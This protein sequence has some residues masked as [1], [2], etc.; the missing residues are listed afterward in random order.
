VT[1]AFE[2]NGSLDWTAIGTLAL[3]GVTFV[4]L[5]FGRR[6]L[7]QTKEE[8]DVSRKE[9]EEAHRPV[10]VPTNVV[11]GQNGPG[12]MV[13]V[14]LENIGTGPALGLRA[15][16]VLLTSDGE[17]AGHGGEHANPG[18]I[19]LGAGAEKVLN[20]ETERWSKGAC[21]ALDAIYEDVA[22]K[23]WQT[24]GN[25]LDDAARPGVWERVRSSPAFSRKRSS[26]P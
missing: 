7:T 1:V 12:S 11:W 2:F 19:A 25:Y 26:Q 8:I 9:V 15:S 14:W 4:S 13:S 22:G 16:I 3:A 5:V 21:F 24:Q 10:V 18:E 20:V 23:L 17:P 6:A